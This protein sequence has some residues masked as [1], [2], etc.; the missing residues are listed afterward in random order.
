MKKT[1][2]F[3][4]LSCLLLV[5]FF[6]SRVWG[7]T[8]ENF[9]SEITLGNDSTLTVNEHITVDF[10]L[11]SKHGIY[12]DIPVRYKRGAVNYNLRLK[13]IS[14]VDGD[15]TDRPY[16]TSRKG[17]YTNIKIGDPS[18]YVRGIQ[19]YNISYQVKRGINYFDDHDE[20]YWNVTGDEWDVTIGEAKALINLPDEIDQ[21]EVTWKS[22][23]GPRGSTSSKAR[24]YWE[25]SR[26]VATLDNIGPREGLTI[27]VSIP[28]GHLIQPGIFLRILWLIQDNGFFFVPVI[29]FVLMF[30]LWFTRG[31]NPK[32]E[33]SIMVKYHPPS[34]LT[35]SEAGTLMD[36]RADLTD[37]TAMTIDL[38]VRGYMKIRQTTSTKLLFL[39]KKDYYFTLLKKDYASDRDLKKHEL[40]FLMGIFESGKTEVALSSLKNKFHLHLPSIRNSLYQG[41]TRNGY[42]SARPDKMRKAYMGFG[43]ALIIGGFFLARSFGRLDLMISFPLSG[44]IVIAFSF[45]MP[46]LSVK[47]VLMLYELLG[48]KEFINRAEKDRLER[49]SKED[50]TVFDRVLPYAMVMGVAD[51]WAEAF[52][53]LYREP[54]GWYESSA[55]PVTGFYTALLVAD[56]G[57]GLRT[58]GATFSSSPSRTS[59]ASGGS[60]FSGGFSGGG[61]GGGGGGSW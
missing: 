19:T 17:T 31:R 14:V 61:F 35:P 47:G 18:R 6:T 8:I 37:I 45:I 41:L 27:V 34:E 32:V 16:Q 54:P 56:L 51:E 15:G 53:D 55:W 22:F 36:E 21:E 11:E 4:G 24:V 3:I 23:T 2:K 49:L 48:L 44:A 13:V 29:V 58:M 9:T 40:S 46:R 39:S 60:G 52:K 33:R 5:C 26:L 10:Q 38:A 1:S 7:W 59:A 30:L 42:F 20:L 28:K 57:E 12:R 25:G 50:P 43:M